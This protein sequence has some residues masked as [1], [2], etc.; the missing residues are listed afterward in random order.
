MLRKT[1][2]S[3]VLML[4]AFTSF[5]QEATDRFVREG[6]L[7]AQSTIA[8]GAMF[9]PQLSNIYLHGSLEYYTDPSLSIRGDSYYFLKTLGD[10]YS[11]YFEKNHSTFA[12]A[13][14]HFKTNG[15]LDPYFAFQPGVAASQVNYD[16][17]PDSMLCYIGSTNSKLTLSPLL[18]G[19]L[20][21]NYYAPKIFHLFLEARY[22]QGKHLSEA[23]SVSLNELK[24]SF[25]LGFN[26]NVKKAH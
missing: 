10:G 12:G 4:A 15:N 22:V 14:Y 23:G 19:V 1:I 6:L 13:S 18:S 20:G 26:I 5:A 9:D 2:S 11:I 17:C 7:R 16:V 25:G 21:F 8:T 24:F 3:I